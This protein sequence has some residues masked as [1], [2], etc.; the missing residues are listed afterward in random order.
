MKA[1][2][3]FSSKQKLKNSEIKSKG[4]FSLPLYPNLKIKDVKIVVSGAGAAAIAC[5]NLYISFGAQLKNIF[6]TK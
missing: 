1:Y 3:K 4:I 5:T 6:I 2:N